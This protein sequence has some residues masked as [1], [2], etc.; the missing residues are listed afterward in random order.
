M[1][2]EPSEN[3]RPATLVGAAA[4]TFATNAGTVTFSLLNVLILA[5]ALGPTGRGEVAFVIA[6]WVLTAGIATLGFE[7][8]NGNLGGRHPERRASLATNSVL[9]AMVLGVLGA[10]IVGLLVTLVPRTRG[11]VDLGLLLFALAALPSGLLGQNLKYLLQSDYRFGV[12]NLAWFASPAVTAVSNGVLALSGALT[13]ERVVLIFVVTNVLAT[14]ILVVSVGRH[15]GY[16]RPDAALARESLSFGLKTHL[17]KFMELGAYRGDQWLLGALVGPYELGLYSIAVSLAEALFYVSGVIVLVQRPHLVRALSEQAAEFAAR[18]FRRAVVLS[19]AVGAALF[20]AAP[21]L[22]VLLFGKAFRGSGDDL[23]FLA[24]GALGVLALDLFSGVVIAQ[25][26]PLMAS[27][28]TAVAL[29]VT[30]ILNIILVPE[31]GGGGTALAKSAAFTAG[32]ATMVVIFLRIFH[33][34]R[35]ALV[36]RLDDVAWYWRKLREGLLSARSAG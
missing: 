6:V 13:V 30:V 34:D 11:E 14:L 21:T 18:I 26:R 19:T 36:P 4:A 15:F 7:E 20:I 16:G 5:R 24:L 9:A 32:G 29:L 17:S 27:A 23:R 10:L 8:A 3:R 22:C 12:T 1:A 31:L 33:A 25:R 35:R 28:G 2:D